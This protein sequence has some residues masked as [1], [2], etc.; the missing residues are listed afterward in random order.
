MAAK[1]RAERRRAFAASVV[2]I[3][4]SGSKYYASVVSIMQS[5]QKY[6]AVWLTLYGMLGTDGGV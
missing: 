6:S 4:Q 1:R 5:V 3:M 2:S